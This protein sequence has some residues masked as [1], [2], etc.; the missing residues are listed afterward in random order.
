[1]RPSH[2]LALVKAAH[3]DQVAFGDLCGATSGA[4]LGLVHRLVDD[5]AAAEAIVRD[6]YVTAWTR[7]RSFDPT[8]DDALPWLLAVTLE[9]VAAH[10]SSL[11]RAP[12]AS[13]TARAVEPHRL[14]ALGDD[15]RRAI[16]LVLAGL[17]L[18]Q[19]ASLTDVEPG[20]AASRLL[21]GLTALG[22][23]GVAAA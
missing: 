7:A 8:R 21:H 17:T 20:V 11:G 3:G 22:T 1:M 2:D 14:A 16:A 9:H 23:D 6:A 13:S 15:E 5:A 19:A 10:S 18:A 4:I 12:S